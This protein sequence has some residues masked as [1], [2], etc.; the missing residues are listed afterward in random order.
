MADVAPD[1]LHERFVGVPVK[2]HDLNRAV[3]EPA[4][5]FQSVCAVEKHLRVLCPDQ[6]GGPPTAEFFEGCDMSVV[7]ASGAQLVTHP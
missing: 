5:R 1:G 7:K 4:G 2:S 6:Q 3:A